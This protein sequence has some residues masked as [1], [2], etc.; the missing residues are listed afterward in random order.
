[1]SGILRI[2]KGESFQ[3]DINYK[4]DSFGV[5]SGYSIFNHQKTDET[6]TMLKGSYKNGKIEFKEYKIISTKSKEP[7]DKMCFIHYKGKYK[8][9]L[10]TQILV[11]EFK[12]YYNNGVQCGEGILTF[13][14]REKLLQKM[15][16]VLNVS[17]KLND[18]SENLDTKKFLKSI[19][20]QKLDNSNTSI[21]WSSDTLFFK[22]WDPDK[23]D[24]DKISITV[25]NIV[26][27]SSLKLSEN[28]FEYKSPINKY[29][30]IVI[31]A[32]NNGYL[33]PNTSNMVL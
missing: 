14:A 9:L 2:K 19:P 11:G 27:E 24:N 16:S 33:P 8:K 32:L 31:K 28:E 21:Q 23:V 25:N 5:L 17:K 7:L 4:L 6:K 1:L 18:S 3:Y 12:G 20:S 30:V 26:V 29:T 22:V 15:D 10:N 13:L